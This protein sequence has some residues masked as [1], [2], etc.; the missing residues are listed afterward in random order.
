MRLIVALAL[1]LSL[2]APAGAQAA[3]PYGIG[4]ES[5]VPIGMLRA[6]SATPMAC[7]VLWPFSLSWRSNRVFPG[8]AVDASGRVAGEFAWRITST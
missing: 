8:A 2:T 1:A 6:F 3:E 5:T 7:A 4:L